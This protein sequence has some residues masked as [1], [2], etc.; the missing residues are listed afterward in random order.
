M[1]TRASAI[2][3]RTKEWLREDKIDIKGF[4]IWKCAI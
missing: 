4:Y 1:E 3:F 2:L